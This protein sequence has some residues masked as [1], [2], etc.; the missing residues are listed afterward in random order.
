MSRVSSDLASAALALA[1]AVEGLALPSVVEFHLVLQHLFP[2][3]VAAVGGQEFRA[4]GQC[5]GFMVLGSWFLVYVSWCL[6]SG[7]WFQV[8]SSSACPC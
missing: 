4:Q 6:V 2:K 1:A 3:N 5:A 7:V 8:Q